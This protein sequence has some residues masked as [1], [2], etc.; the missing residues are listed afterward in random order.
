MRIRL[1]SDWVDYY[2]HWFD[3]EGPEWWRKTT[4]G[5][6]RR[7][8]LMML[9]AAGWAVPRYANVEDFGIGM[10]VVHTD[11]RAHRGEGKSLALLPEDAGQFAPT[12]LAVEYVMPSSDGPMGV[13]YR[14]LRLGSR[15]F[16]LK[17]ENTGD[18]RSNFGP[19][20]WITRLTEAELIGLPRG[21]VDWP[22]P[23]IAVDCVRR[24]ENGVLRL[25]AIDLN[26]AP[27]LTG[28]GIEKLLPAEAAAK[29]IK[30]WLAASTGGPR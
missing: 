27:G 25:L 28:T 23:L 16:W 9:V 3:A 21:R 30:N 8:M 24:C 29:E 18:W 7:T 10:A 13:S 11:E 6:D 5:P 20:V 15:E 22:Y 4:D 12:A 26:V 17:Y 14:C 19:D 2:D 1:V